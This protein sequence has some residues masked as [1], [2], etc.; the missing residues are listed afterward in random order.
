MY[1]QEKKYLVAE[2]Y[3]LADFLCF[4][5]FQKISSFELGL[6]FVREDTQ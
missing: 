1:A 2:I 4:L 6:T 3:F 5:L